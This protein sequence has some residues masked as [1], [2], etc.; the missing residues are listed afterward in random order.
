MT[1]AGESIPEN[2]QQITG[3]WRDPHFCVKRRRIGPKDE[4]EEP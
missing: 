3:A 2:Y 4:E 1:T